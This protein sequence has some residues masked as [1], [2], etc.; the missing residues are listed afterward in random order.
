M[1]IEPIVQGKYYH[2]YNRGINGT[3]LFNENENYLYFLRLYEKY[4]ELVAETFAWCLMG[5]HFHLLVRIKEIN[6]IKNLSGIGGKNLSGLGDPK[7]LVEAT[8]DL[9]GFENPKGLDNKNPNFIITNQ[10]SKFF[11]AYAKAFNKRYKR[12]GSLFEKPFDRKLVNNMNYFR[13]LIFYIHYNPVHH[14]FCKSLQDYPWSSYG[15]II[16]LKPSK[17]VQEKVLG[18]FDSIGN[19]ID[20]HEQMHDFNDLRDMLFD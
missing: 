1:N 11:N 7:G 12:T 13:T 20:Y 10:F 3:R 9:S 14:G 15:S 8:S 16:S 17:I 19:F 2:I 6:E 18:Y 5:N 4:I